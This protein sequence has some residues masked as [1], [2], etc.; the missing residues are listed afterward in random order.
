MPSRYRLGFGIAF[1]DVNNDG[2]LDLAT[3]NGHVDDFRPDVP[4]QMRAQLFT[5]DEDGLRLVDVTDRAGPPFQV[6]LLGRGL[7]AG[8]LDNDGRVDLLIL[9]Q[10]QPL[11]YFHNKT[12]GG[13]W[14]TLAAGRHAVRIATPWEP[15]S[16]SVAGGR[17]FVGWR[18]GGGSYQSAS[19]PRLHFGLGAVDR[20]DS[21]EVTWPSGKVG[22]F[23][24]LA[25]NSGTC[26][27]RLTVALIGLRDFHRTVRRLR[28]ATNR[29][30][31]N[32]L[33]Q[34]PVRGEESLSVLL[35]AHVFQP[36]DHL[37]VEPLL[38]G[39]VRHGRTR[40]R[41]VPVLLARREP[42]HVAGT[43]LLDRATLPL[44]PAAAGRDDEGLAQRVGVPGRPGPGLQRD[45]VA[46]RTGW[47]FR[48]EQRVD[49][50]RAGEPVGRPL[51]DGCDPTS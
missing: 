26:C 12:E 27:V 1:L 33:P 45:A 44:D 8:D 9:S 2:R 38:D 32:R 30:S 46:G 24:N 36:I 15:G 6:P 22:R 42:D 11:S 20:I 48:R 5:G 51:A 14:L 35:I 31:G 17:R 7:A 23:P 10:N 18:I 34:G 3:A 39:D 43:D 50:D 41:P 19:D 49:A 16:P 40:R 28:H 37:A 13:H 4:Y 21:V 29:R 47:H 25:V